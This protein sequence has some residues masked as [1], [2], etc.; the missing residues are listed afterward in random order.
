MAYEYIDKLSEQVK[1]LSDKELDMLAKYPSIAQVPTV[2]G[3]TTQDTT[4]IEAPAKVRPIEMPSDYK[5]ELKQTEPYME[6]AN[7]A[8]EARQED[9]SNLSQNAQQAY[10]AQKKAEISYLQAVEDLRKGR[11]PYKTPDWLSNALENQKTKAE[12]PEKAPERSMLAEAI[13][14]FSPGLA[15]VLG[16]ESAALAAPEAQK[17]GRNLYET[18]RKEE[19]DQVNTRNKAVA[20]K[21]EKLAKLDKAYADRWLNDQKLSTDQARAVIEGLKLPITV[22]Q[23]DAS[24]A[25]SQ[26]NAAGKEILTATTTAAGKTA[27]LETLPMREANKTKR[28]GIMATGQALK[29]ATALRKEF[30]GLPEVKDFRDMTVAYKK[31][32]SSSKNPSPAGDISL[33]FSYMKMLDPGSTVRET[34]YATAK[35][36][37]NVPDMIRNQFNKLRDGMF[38]NEKQREDFLNQARNLYNAQQTLV[39]Q[40]EKDYNMLAGNYGANPKNVLPSETKSIPKQ[41]TIKD[42]QALDWAKKNANDP[43]AALILKKLGA[44]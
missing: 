10:E 43:R 2:P 39:S 34:E 41:M 30:E 12:A 13:L 37:A 17:Q 31:I 25:T 11:E 42:Q 5:F 9:K 32:E 7:R 3:I 6:N 23:K 14:A 8:I 20:D 22:N 40:R 28:A 4:A 36:A 15:G 26:A 1:K 35:N 33:V 29:D 16:G 27:D 19:V 44:K 21:Y 24:E 18:Y 38:L